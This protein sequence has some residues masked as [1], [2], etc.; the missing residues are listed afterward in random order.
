MWYYFS[1]PGVKHVVVLRS[2]QVFNDAVQ[3]TSPLWLLGLRPDEER[4]PDHFMDLMPELR[5]QARDLNPTF[6]V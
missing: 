5:L 2:A 6:L 4:G 3:P 1:P